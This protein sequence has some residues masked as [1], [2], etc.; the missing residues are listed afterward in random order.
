M[1]ASFG[2]W[3]SPITSDSITS[4]SISFK[5]MQATRDALYWL[6]GRPSEMGRVALVSYDGNEETD[7][8][9]E[10]SV[11]TR[12]HEYGGGAFAA[13]KE[14]IYSNGEDGQLYT[15]DGKKL[16]DAPNCRF[17]DG[18]NRIWV[19]EKHGAEVENLLVFVGDDKVHELASGHDFYSSP[20]ISP[21]GKKLAFI[22]WDF[23]NM[24]WDSSTLWL[25]DIDPEHKLQNLK[26][27][28]GGPDE[29]VCQVQ[30][31]S[32]GNLHFVSDKTGFWNL[33]RQKDGVVENL[34]PM[35]AEFGIPAWVFGLPTY[36]FLTDGKILC[37]YTVKGVDH[38]GK[39]DPKTKSLE[40]LNQPFTRIMNLVSY[41]DKVYFFGATPTT[42][43]SII[44]YDPN[45]NSYETLKQSSNASIT[46][47]WISKGEVLEYPSMDGKSGYAFYYPPK[48]PDYEAPEGEMPPV[49]ID[50]HG[51]PTGRSYTYFMLDV[52]YWTS[53]G[54]AVVDV[55]YGGSTGY[56]R[57]YFKRLEKNWGVLDVA[58]CIAAAHALVD[59]GLADPSKLI[60][61]GGSAGGYTALAALAFHN[62]F[63]AGTSYFGVSDL[64]LLYEDTHKFEAKYTDILV[65]PFPEE[66]ELIRSRSP[67]HSAD[68]ISSPVLLLQ[69]DEDK[70][71]P[72]NQSQVIYEAL[73][74]NNIPV[75]MLL[76]EGEGHGFRK[77][78]SIK[79]SLDAEL[80]FY[81]EILGIE[82][83]EPFD[84]PPV[85]IVRD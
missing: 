72:P 50:A 10:L 24:Q 51:G 13:G 85:E 55:N 54:F 60:I 44:A 52:Q 29:S 7:L 15:L 1:T 33:Y 45:E 19:A 62:V 6:E 20:R 59:K 66:V 78:D 35:E 64:E 36:T 14:F 26:P 9:N 23:P 40:D 47:D 16:T 11:R 8:L 28:S 43:V 75:G 39:I 65:A 2:S 57:E 69:G 30:W 34:C 18:A 68:Q 56:G 22:T 31:S 38:L 74:K 58:D 3:E 61:R 70:V 42:P 48:N 81:S 25:A 41:K 79:R 80:Y 46:E 49:I 77:A 4:E 76:F 12:V 53:R 84:E 63:A 5:E 32:E 21:D 27:I 73:K 67:V 71:V 37:S 83:P 17:A 82:L